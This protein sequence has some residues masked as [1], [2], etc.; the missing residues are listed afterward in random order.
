MSDVRENSWSAATMAAV[1]GLAV[2]SC[3]P[4]VQTMRPTGPLT[5]SA[6]GMPGAIIAITRGEGA[7]EKVVATQAGR[8]SAA[9][10]VTAAETAAMGAATMAAAHRPA[11]VKIPMAGIGFRADR[12]RGG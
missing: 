8:M 10:M 12:E 4:A 6:A 11:G 2:R 3:V 7:A 9:R 5:V 1:C